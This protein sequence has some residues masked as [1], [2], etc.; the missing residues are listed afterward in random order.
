MKVHYEHIAQPADASWRFFLRE[1]PS[2]PFEWHYH[3]EYELTLTLNSRG[4]RY[5]GDHIEPYESGDLVLTGPNLPH[6]WASRSDAESG[7]HRVYVLWFQQ[8][9]VDHLV[10]GFPEFAALTAMLDASRRGLAWSHALAARL[11]P[12][13]AQLPSASAQQR[14]IHLLRILHEL[15]Q[16]QPR[17]LASTDFHSLT[18]PAREQ[19]RLTPLLDQLH[20]DY[21]QPLTLA[22]L[23]RNHHMSTSTLNRFFR[24]QMNQT[25]HQYLTQIRIGQAC[26]DLIQSDKPINLIADQSGFNNLSNFNRLFKRAKGV[27]PLAFRNAYQGRR[28]PAGFRSQLA[29]PA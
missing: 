24:Q 20:Q 16:E 6:S 13:F 1:L 26:A 17:W 11:E 21:R 5:V 19:Q 25:V 8:A 12:E 22:E 4:E 7:L 18:S 28:Q 15:H 23:A 27:T 10:Q 3:P 9:W 29:G 14:T 2:L